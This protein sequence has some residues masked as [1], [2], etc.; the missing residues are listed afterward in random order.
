MI[1]VLL[2]S[3]VILTMN[4]QLK[5]GEPSKTS[6]QT[7]P[8]EYARSFYIIVRQQNQNIHLWARNLDGAVDFRQL[9]EE[10]GTVISQQVYRFNEKTLYTIQ[11]SPGQQPVLNKTPNLEPSAIGISNIIAGPAVWALQYGV[12]DNQVKT[13]QGVLNITIKSANQLIDDA[14]FDPTQSVNLN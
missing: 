11:Q 12:G 9:T 1:P 10:N 3:T 4:S 8:S 6:A 2:V 5:R 7:A 14:V 13:Q